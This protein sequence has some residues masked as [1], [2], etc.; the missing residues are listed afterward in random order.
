MYKSLAEGHYHIVTEFMLHSHI[1]L[2]FEEYE[3]NT[4]RTK[5][6]CSFQYVYNNVSYESF[7][8]WLQLTYD[9][10]VCILDFLVATY[11]NNYVYYQLL[12]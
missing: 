4:C 8:L 6:H 5:S 7:E 12:D 1:V 11:F 10:C 2:P 3:I 9:S